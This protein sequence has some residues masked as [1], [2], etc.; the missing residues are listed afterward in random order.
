MKN[1]TVG[2]IGGT[3]GMGRWFATL[4]QKEGCKVHVWGRK[5]AMSIEDLVAP[6]NVIVVA[7][8]ISATASLIKQFGPLLREDMLLM[9]LTSLKK[10]P[11]ELMAASTRAEVIGCHPLFG[12]ALDDPAGQNVVLCPVRGGRWLPWLREILTKNGLVVIEKNPEEHD[13][14]MAVVQALNHLNTITLGTAIAATG[15][16]LSEINKFST[17]IFRAKMEI[18][19]KYSPKARNF[20]RTSS[21][22]IPILI[23][24]WN[25]TKKRWLISAV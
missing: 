13:K 19:K 24:C 3:H 2:I 9:D 5:T 16:P 1:V 21:V 23:K 8:P 14:M 20:T 22:K 4:L 12:P 17:P 7:V 18:V 10:E 11:V 6:C 15:I 25:S